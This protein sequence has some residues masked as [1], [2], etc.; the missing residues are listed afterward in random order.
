MIR[1]PRSVR[2][3]GVVG[4][5]RVGQ[6]RGQNRVGEVGQQRAHLDCGQLG[7]VVDDAAHHRK[8][9]R[10]K[11][12]PLMRRQVRPNHAQ[13]LLDSMVNAA[14]LRY[15]CG[16]IVAAQV[17]AFPTVEPAGLAVGHRGVD[18]RRDQP[19][20]D[21]LRIVGRGVIRERRAIHQLLTEAEHRV[22]EEFVLARVM[23]VQRGRGD[24]HAGRDGFHA[25]TVEAQR[26]ERLGGS[27]RDLRFAVLGAAPNCVAALWPG[28]RH[29]KH[30]N[31]RY[32]HITLDLR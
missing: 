30:H 22:A 10:R 12:P 16:L 2:L 15:Q 4:V 13:R 29:G 28:A 6:F 18:E 8:D 32:A 17:P 9:R 27:P 20:Q 21:E 31:G 1:R 23:P 5:L 3:D 24:S 14:H 11:R 7:P 26:T 19:P 25:H